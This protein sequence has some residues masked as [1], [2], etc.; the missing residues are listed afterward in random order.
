MIRRSGENLSTAKQHNKE[1]SANV[2]R[3]C[4]CGS[5]QQRDNWSIVLGGTN[6][7]FLVENR[8]MDNATQLI[9]TA[10]LT[11][12]DFI[13]E[14]ISVEYEDGYDTTEVTLDQ[15]REITEDEL[16]LRAEE[17]PVS[18]RPVDRRMI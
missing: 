14:E 2:C 7:V 10:A 15:I 3:H 5:R 4:G 9:R 17:H 13:T 12:E 6:R 8:G 18:F 16:E 1:S 11:S